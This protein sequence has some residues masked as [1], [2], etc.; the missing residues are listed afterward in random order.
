MEQFYCNK[1]GINTD[2]RKKRKHLQ[3]WMYRKGV[4][5]EQIMD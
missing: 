3:C 5:S 2:G 1:T 4:I